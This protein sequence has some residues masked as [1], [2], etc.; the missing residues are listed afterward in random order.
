MKYFVVALLSLIIVAVISLPFAGIGLL[1][2]H[3]PYIW[4]LSAVAGQFIIGGLWNTLTNKILRNKIRQT[5]LL[6]EIERSSKYVILN[7]AYCSVNNEASIILNQDN[8]FTCKNCKQ[9][10]KV[11]INYVV[12]RTTEPVLQNNVIKEI[13]DKVEKDEDGREK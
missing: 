13:I 3:N 6:E 5:E 12:S 7:C 11:D 10:N 8:K 2:G 4:G 1:L 9:R